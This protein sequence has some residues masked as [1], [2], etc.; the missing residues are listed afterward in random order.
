MMRRKPQ[1]HAEKSRLRELQSA[2]LTI[3]GYILDPRYDGFKAILE[4]N[5][6]FTHQQYADLNAEMRRKGWNG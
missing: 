4:R 5:L 6:D 2:I 1:F 3:E